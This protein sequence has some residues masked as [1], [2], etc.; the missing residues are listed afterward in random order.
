MDRRSSDLSKSELPPSSRKLWAVIPAAGSGLRYAS[1][2]E[3]APGEPSGDAPAEKQFAEVAGRPVLLWS[4][5]KVLAASSRSLALGGVVLAAP[6]RS[7]DAITQLVADRPDQTEAAEIRVV[8]GGQTRQQSVA[9]ALA[10]CDVEDGDLVLI[11]DAARP[12]VASRD[13]KAVVEVAAKSEVTGAVLGRAM[14]DTVKRVEDGVLGETLDR[15]RLFRVETPQVF[16]AEALTAA[17]E[18]A[19]SEGVDATDESTLVERYGGRVLAVEATA[20]N[21]KLTLARDLERIAQLLTGSR[22]PDQVSRRR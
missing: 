15:E 6:E 8:S 18:R 13:V 20:E 11:H 21:P 7:V 5:E 3:S 17:L 16:R 1:S 4:L 12:A 10:C 9:R 19:A 14:T 22:E 2:L